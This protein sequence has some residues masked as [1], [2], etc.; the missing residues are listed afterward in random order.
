MTFAHD[1]RTAPPVAVR[2]RIHVAAHHPIVGRAE[3]LA[4]K[5][6]IYGL[7]AV[8]GLIGAR[9]ARGGVE[10]TAVA[11]AETLAHVRA[12]G[13]VLLEQRDGAEARESFRIEASD[14]PSELGPQDLVVLAVKATALP[15]V[16]SAIEPLLGPGTAVLTAM[17]GIPWWFFHGLPG[18]AGSLQVPSLDPGGALARA[19]PVKHILGS[20]LHFSASCPEP[21]TVRHGAG[22]RIIVG[23]PEGGPAD[24]RVSAVAETLLRGG[25]DVDVSERIQEDIWFKLWGNMTMNPLSA[26]T[27][28][29]MDLILDDPLVRQ[30][31]AWCM[32]EAAE[33][34]ARIGLPIDQTPE[35]RQAVTRQLGAV[36][37]SMLQD[38]DNGR[39]IELDAMVTAVRELA[40]QVGVPTPNIDTLL[41]LARLH[42]RVLGLYPAETPVALVNSE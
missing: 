17:N 5:V 26:V 39:S 29:T 20:V 13:L 4:V 14:R 21:G 25:F 34:G 23:D 30:F 19:I 31:V 9:L 22:N 32:T 16:A 18:A 24:A 15:A 33:V 11:R 8:G 6:C 37:T 27:G 40:M 28:A 7:G 10:V 42:A 38:I 1:Q 41:G 2:G 35:E 12:Q 3:C 36:R